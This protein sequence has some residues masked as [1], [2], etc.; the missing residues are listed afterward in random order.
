MSLT[1]NT[2]I[3]STMVQKNL[4]RSQEALATSFDRLSSGLRITKAGDD[5]AGLA[6]SEKLRAEIRALQQASRNANDGISLL[7][8]AEG[9]LNEVSSILVRM[10]ELATQAASGQL[11]ASDRG[12]IDREFSSLRAEIDRIVDATEFNGRKLLDGSMAAGVVFQVGVHNDAASQI[13]VT[14]ADTHASQLGTSAAALSVQS[15]STAAG[16]QAALSVIDA[17]IEDVVAVRGSIGAVQNRFA[18]VM[19]NLAASVEN[20]TAAN[21][22]IRDVDVAKE[23]AEMTRSQILSQAGVAVLAQ[24]NQVPSLA[25]TLL[26]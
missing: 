14:I 17:A 12:H 15:L 1:I 20:M 25:L 26:R 4:T 6:I 16:A 13:T 7:Q 5:A 23:T 24:A 21:S 10:R 11:S 8:T 18:S 9:A 3:A 19:S 22:R 2:N